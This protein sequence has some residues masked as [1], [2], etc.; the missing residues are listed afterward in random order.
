VTDYYQQREK[1]VRDL[2]ENLA[3]IETQFPRDEKLIREARAQLAAAESL[4]AEQVAARSANQNRRPRLISRVE[5]EYT[6][7]ARAKGIKGAV[8]LAVTVAKDGSVQ[9]VFIKRA[10]FPSLDESAIQAARKMRFEPALQ[11]GEA[12]SQAITVEFY[13]SPQAKREYVEQVYDGGDYVDDVRG[14]RRR[15]DQ[16]Y[17]AQDERAR[18]QAELT[19]A[20]VITMDRAVQ[21]ATSKYPGKVL[22]CSLGRDKNGPVFYHV[23]IIMSEGDK[24]T[25]KYVWVSAIDGTIIK[26]EEE[27]REVT[28]S[29]VMI[30][31]G[32]LNGKATSLPLPAYP[33]I[34]RAAR[35]SGA[36]TVQVTINVQGSVVVAS[37]VSGHPLLRDA[38][39]SAARQAK[40]APT[41]L[42]G[43][44]VY[45]SGQLI[46]HF[47]AQ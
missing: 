12:V 33:A 20:A 39:V 34:A 8:L 30:Q 3:R 32:V 38:A 27:P 13:F 7:D 29:G 9:D 17:V 24:R 5:P 31:G 41:Y 22:A 16:E 37:A 25:T 35:A 15:K 43:Q 11:N 10:L 23:V 40:F 2:R 18:R 4:Y 6:A 47:V 28:V 36:V 1:Q 26:T 44:P 19:E 14:L 21:I 46:Y 42:Q 45:V